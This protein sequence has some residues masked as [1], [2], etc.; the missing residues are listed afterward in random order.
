MCVRVQARPEVTPVFFGF[1]VALV[2]IVCLNMFIGI[3][4]NAF[5]T[6]SAITVRLD[7]PVC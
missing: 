1:Y 6:V 4:S 2:F 3:I 7:L 5:Y